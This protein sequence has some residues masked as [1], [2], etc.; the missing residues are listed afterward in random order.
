MRKQHVEVCVN[1]D[2]GA[3]MTWNWIYL[4]DGLCI[5]ITTETKSKSILIH[6][7]ELDGF[8]WELFNQGMRDKL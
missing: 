8:E 6:C 5:I 3:I 2:L 4:L 1:Q 7:F